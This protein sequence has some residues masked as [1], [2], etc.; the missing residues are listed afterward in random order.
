ER[1]RLEEFSNSNKATPEPFRADRYRL[2]LSVPEF[3]TSGHLDQLANR[4][5]K[6]SWFKQWYKF[7]GGEWLEEW[8]GAQIRALDLAPKPEIT[9]GVDAYRGERKAQLEVD[10]A[11][12]RGYRS[13]F[14]SCTTNSGKALC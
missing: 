5:D 13:Y 7:I 2:T 1:Q 3:P 11:V 9:V 12:V 8:I 4:K 6:D 14:I 10:V